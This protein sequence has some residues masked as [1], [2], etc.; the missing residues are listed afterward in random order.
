M[1]KESKK[2]QQKKKKEV[3]FEKEENPKEGNMPQLPQR[4]KEEWHLEDLF[5]GPPKESSKNQ[6]QGEGIL[7]LWIHPNEKPKQ[8]K[9]LLPSLMTSQITMSFEP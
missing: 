5:F 8:P 4:F 3:G 2:P 1:T 7:K 9:K 6:Q